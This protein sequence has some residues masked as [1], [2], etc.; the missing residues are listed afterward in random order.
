MEVLSDMAYI[1]YRYCAYYIMTGDSEIT[2]E[3]EILPDLFDIER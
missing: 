2:V 3:F 1:Y